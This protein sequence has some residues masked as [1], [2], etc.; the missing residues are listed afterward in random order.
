MKFQAFLLLAVLLL[1]NSVWSCSAFMLEDGGRDLWVGKSFDYPQ[2]YGK[3]FV[4]YSGVEKESLTFGKSRKLRWVSRYSNITFNQILRDYPYG[5]MNEEGLVVE[6]LWLKES[7][8]QEVKN[9][10]VTVNESQLIQYLLD[11][12]SSTAQAIEKVRKVKVKPIMAKVHY[13]ICDRSK[14]CQVVE[15]LN[16]KLVVHQFE[17][18]RE[19]IIQNMPYRKERD[20]LREKQRSYRNNKEE[21]SRIFSVS[22]KQELELAREQL[23]KVELLKNN[24]PE[25]RWQIAYNLQ[26]GEVF[27]KKRDESLPEMKWLRIDELKRNCRESLTSSVLDFTSIKLNGPAARELK[28]FNKTDNVELLDAFKG[29]P[30]KVKEAGLSH[31]YKTHHCLK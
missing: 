28:D 4:N 1:Q 14:D 27:F 3:V 22:N 26:K 19:S 15:Y 8:F 29:V 16:G 9:D 7:S 30:Q 21:L 23:S 2:G 17:S 6:I 20:L 11:T 10:D 13:L 25:T 12:A 5:G 18:E 31:S 24:R